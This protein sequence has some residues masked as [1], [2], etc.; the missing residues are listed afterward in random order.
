MTS[1][2][3]LGPSIRTEVPPNPLGG[4]APAQKLDG[5]YSQFNGSTMNGDGQA[6]WGLPELTELKIEF[7]Q[8]S[9]NQGRVTLYQVEIL[10]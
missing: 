10:A 5:A 3:S 7:E 8:T 2:G 6:A 9:D 1:Q 4:G